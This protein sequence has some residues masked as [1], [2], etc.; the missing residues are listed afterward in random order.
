MTGFAAFHEIDGT[1][2]LPS[3]HIFRVVIRTNITVTF[4]DHV[5]W[6]GNTSFIETI[7]YYSLLHLISSLIRML[8]MAERNYLAY[9]DL[10][11]DHFKHQS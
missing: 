6:P 1:F 8:K 3:L 4:F 9:A 2:H 7:G 5:P 11:R 10:D